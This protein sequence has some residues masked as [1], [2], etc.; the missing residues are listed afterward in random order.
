MAGLV[1]AA[2]FANVAKIVGMANGGMLTGGINGVDSIPLMGQRGELVVPKRSFSQVI[3]G[4]VA[5][6]GL[7]KNTKS[8]PSPIINL[9]VQGNIIAD[10][11]SQIDN[12]ITRISDT[13]EFR[14][15]KLYGVT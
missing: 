6:R 2:G 9:T 4:E 5:R 7:S 1:G 10:D 14:N 8:P 12:L 3:D 15:A 13:L 11:D